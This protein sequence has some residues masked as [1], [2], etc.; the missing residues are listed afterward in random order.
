MNA[1]SSVEFFT[2]KEDDVVE[3]YTPLVKR[4]AHHMASRL[5]ASI[6]FDDLVQ[7]GLIGLLEAARNYEEGHNAS[8]ETYAGIRIRGAMLDEIR[9][10]DWAPRSVQKKA[11]MV[12]EAVR[13]IEREEGRDAR[14]QEIADKLGLSV[15]DYFHML[16]DASGQRVLSLEET[17]VGD[18]V[19][20]DTISDN[21]P[22]VLDDMHEE[23]IVEYLAGAISGLPERERLVMALYYVEEFNLREI[24][25]VIGLSESRI[26]QIHNQANIRLRARLEDF[27]NNG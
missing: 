25:T 6:Q 21:R 1:R 8:F 10:N 22:G 16:Q 14:A 23:D 26:C 11:R 20:G 9:K 5:P 24:G 2:L 13:Q 18:E 12:A 27:L 7:A 4:I 3:I 19:L 15:D 17:V